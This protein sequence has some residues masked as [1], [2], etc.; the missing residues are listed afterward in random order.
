M[1]EF[2]RLS[3]L[4]QLLAETRELGAVT[5]A[6]LSRSVP[7]GEQ[8][9]EAHAAPFG[10]HSSGSNR[11]IVV[12]LHDITH[13]R[14]LERVRRDFVANVSHELKT[15][16]AAI[17]GFVESLL[18]GA[19]H[20]DDN[21]ERF[22]RR[23]ES[24]V[25][26]LSTII[27]DLLTLAR[28]ESQGET[29]PRTAVNWSGIVRSRVREHAGIAEAKGLEMTVD[30][31]AD[32][33][34]VL[35]D[36]ESLVQVVDNLLSNAVRYTQKGSVQVRLAEG[37]THGV[38]EVEDTGDGIPEGD[39]DRIFERFYRLDK[40]RS[41]EAGGTGLGL[42][43]VRNLVQVLGGNVRVES[44]VGRGSRFTVE[45]PLAAG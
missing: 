27:T 33:V 15:P 13:L 10:Q 40:A 16:L 22:L 34:T 21:N 1:W 11:D 19:L 36:A 43:I 20:D 44:Q 38:L 29:Q 39:L 23:I 30:S 26:R 9:L 5:R 2:V 42:S 41:R 18:G 3:G 12:V 8:E 35:G 37:R 25:E 45:L 32:P 7:G 17:R 28:I 6:D 14:H 31:I 4:E 24:N